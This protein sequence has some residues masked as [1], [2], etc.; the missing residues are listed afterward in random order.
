MPVV[1]VIEA[2]VD[3]IAVTVASATGSLE[4]GG[5]ILAA[6]DAIAGAAG[7]LTF[8]NGIFQGLEAWSL[9]AG[10][11]GL[12]ANRPKLGAGGNPTD[13]KADMLAPVPYVIGRT[14]TAGVTSATPGWSSVISPGARSFSSS[15]V[16]NKTDSA[17]SRS[18][19]SASLP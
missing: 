13:F 6:G 2:A 17:N 15:D 5:D 19:I 8:A 4:I 16:A 7:T 14:G 10:L 12:G 1:A 3:W 18:S 11:A 9:V